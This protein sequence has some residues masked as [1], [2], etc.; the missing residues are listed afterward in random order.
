MTLSR[1]FLGDYNLIMPD[2]PV[3]PPPEPSQARPEGDRDDQVQ[4]ALAAPPR[5]GNT[6]WVAMGLVMLVTYL[7]YLPALDNGFV[8]WDDQV[9]I[10]NNQNFRGF[11]WPR[12][13]WM[14]SSALFGHYQPLTWLTYAVDYTFWGMDPR[15]YHLTSVL[16]HVAAAG[17]FFWVARQLL[18]SSFRRRAAVGIG[19]TVSAVLA[20]LLFAIHPLRVE[21]VA[22][23]T[24]RRDVV[25]GL[26]F[27]IALGGYLQAVTTV[28]DR[29]ARRKWF[30]ISLV[31][32]ALS[33]LGKAIGV[34]LPVILVLIDA[35]PLRRLGR[36]G[37]D[38][39]R[40]EVRPIWREK[41]P[42]LLMAVAAGMT[43][44][45][46]QLFGQ[47]IGSLDRVPLSPRIAF[48]FYSSALY[49]YKTILP[50][51][52]SPLYAPSSPFTPITWYFLLSGAVVVL[53]TVAIFLGRRRWPA[54]PVLWIAYL[55]ILAPVIGIL[56]TGPQMAADRYTYL[57]CLGWPVLA[58]AGWLALWQR[59]TRGGPWQTAFVGASSF[60]ISALVCL[61]WLT[62]QQVQAWHDTGSLWTQAV[63]V[64][65]D[66]GRAHTALGAWYAQHGDL[67]RALEHH[68]LGVKHRPERA[69]G[70]AQL[71]LTL[72]RMGRNEEA[73]V[74]Y[75]KAIDINPKASAAHTGLGMVLV[76]SRDPIKVREGLTYLQKAVELDPQN[77]YARINLASYY[78][79][80]A[81]FS[82]ADAVLREGLKRDPRNPSY[83][84]KLA[85]LLATCPEPRQRNGPEA[86]TLARQACAGAN[87]P[88]P[89]VLDALAAALAEN[90]QFDQAARTAGQAAQLARQ[91]GQSRLAAAI[92]A[93]ISTY[94]QGRPWRERRR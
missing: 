6:E 62:P 2:A 74:A 89:V 84:A 23:A 17:A 45:L 73:I 33:L 68:R 5:P 69:A 21:S 3:A 12:I 60:A 55:V 1:S 15:G 63:H 61:A 40:P 46:V 50:V 20:T 67:E 64:H 77:T 24:E 76:T 48:S 42:Y 16:F 7:V 56:Q 29:A 93:R 57:S 8:E 31:A 54:G 86:L 9:N 34:S 26:F 91:A 25:S 75:R 36:F 90:G 13:R 70:Y 88:R 80:T 14:F 4:P 65:P 87:R 39:L 78:Q 53:I 58:A 82:Q 66:N 32:Y 11:D 19:L 28:G 71:G 49:L 92:E 94:Q 37:R 22:W 38:W 52:L 27:V 44:F 30:R 81:R 51:G 18:H 83:S 43:G 41:L 85:W 72:T 47:G 35:Y 10:L 79:R 59:R